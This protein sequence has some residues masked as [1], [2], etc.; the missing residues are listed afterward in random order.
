MQHKVTIH[1]PR[2]KEVVNLFPA[3]TT[4]NAEV[5]V[6]VSERGGGRER[7]SVRACERERAREREQKRV[8]KM[9]IMQDGCLPS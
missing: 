7:A 5:N 4:V 2:V 3:L 1:F 8:K 6:C 9:A